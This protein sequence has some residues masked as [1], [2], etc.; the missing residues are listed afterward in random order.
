[1]PNEPNTNKLSEINHK[2]DFSSREK[3]SDNRQRKYSRRRK[4]KRSV[5]KKA[6]YWVRDNPLKVAAILCLGV[7]IYITVLFIKR[8][9]EERTLKGIP[10]VRKAALVQE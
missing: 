8:S 6:I 10:E 2:T 4:R 9:K 3:F 7:L 5:F 1:L